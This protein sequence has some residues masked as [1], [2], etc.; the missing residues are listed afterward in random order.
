[1]QQANTE[2]AR[3]L[4][5]Y[6]GSSGGE[7]AVDAAAALLGPRPAVVLNV[8]PAMTFAEGIAASASPVPGTAFE[9]LN[10][11]EALR[12]AEAG[13]ARARH[14][15]LD[16]EARAMLAP[17]AWQ[18]IVDVADELDAA[19]IVIGARGLSGLREVARGSVSHDVT[20]HARRPVLIV[21]PPT[22]RA[23]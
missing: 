4:I 6:D 22:K 23:V 18:G 10:R 9:D 1:M 5:C 16:A 19:V 13:A 3:I 15:G 17:T 12:L 7:R 20:T 11:A 8:Q 14:A 21:P 2:D